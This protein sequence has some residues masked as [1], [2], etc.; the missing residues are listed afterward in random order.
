MLKSIGGVDNYLSYHILRVLRVAMPIKLRGDETKTA[1]EMGIVVDTLF[2]VQPFDK[3]LCIQ[4]PGVVGKAF[5][6]KCPGVVG[7]VLLQS[8]RE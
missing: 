8:V 5:V 2:Q 3:L 7:K 6:T 1:R 4:C